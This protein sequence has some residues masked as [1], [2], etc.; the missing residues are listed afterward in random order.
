[1]SLIDFAKY[2]AKNRIGISDYYT[3]MIDDEEYPYLFNR[4][5]CMDFNSNHCSSIFKEIKGSC[6]IRA[7]DWEEQT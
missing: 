6:L 5:R 2:L 4:C 3:D 1:M 7:F